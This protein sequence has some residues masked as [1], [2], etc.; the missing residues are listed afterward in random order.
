MFCFR[1]QEPALN[2]E[3]WEFLKVEEFL[4]IFNSAGI[5][6][7]DPEACVSVGTAQSQHAPVKLARYLVM[8]L[9]PLAP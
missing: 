5:L 2:F 6:G 8:D 3:N 9:S 4:G 1:K 7:I